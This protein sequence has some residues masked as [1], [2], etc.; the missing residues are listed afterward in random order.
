M[1]LQVVYY[2]ILAQFR[3][4][5]KRHIRLYQKSLSLTKRRVRPCRYTIKGNQAGNYVEDVSKDGIEDESIH[6]LAES[7]G[8]DKSTNNERATKKRED[9]SCAF[10]NADSLDLLR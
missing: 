3:S 1:R 5:N 8:E 7:R 4:S 10:S 6:G 9:R 2:H